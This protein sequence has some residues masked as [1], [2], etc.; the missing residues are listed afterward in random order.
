MRLHKWNSIKG[1][2][3]ALAVMMLLSCVVLV[4]NETRATTNNNGAALALGTT[5]PTAPLNLQADAGNKFVWLW[6]I[7]RQIR[8][9]T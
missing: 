8:E 5:V 1:L 4:P 9:A 3:I 6:W 7:T 2:G